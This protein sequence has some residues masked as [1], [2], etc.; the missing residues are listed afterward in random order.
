VELLAGA[1][2]GL[3]VP[4]WTVL[5][6]R[7]GLAVTVPVGH[8]DLEATVSVGPLS[9]TRETSGAGLGD[10]VSRLQ[11]GW[12]H[13]DFSHLVWVQAV[14]PTGRYDTGFFPIVGLHRHPEVLT[15][16]RKPMW[17][18]EVSTGWACRAAGR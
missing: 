15:T 13:G 9:A 11:L 4:D 17:H 6:G 18:V 8:I 12:E 2:S 1:V 10:V 7:P 16:H 3:Y 14:A 5:G